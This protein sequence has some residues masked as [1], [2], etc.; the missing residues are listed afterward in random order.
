M[1]YSN[2]QKKLARDIVQTSLVTCSP[3][4]SILSVT[5][6]MTEYSCS[7]ILVMEND[8][9]L[10]IWTERDAVRHNFSLE[11]GELQPVSEVMMSPVQ[12]IPDT[13]NLEDVSEQ[14]RR[15]GFR[16]FLVED[17]KGKRIGV[18]SQTDVV[19]KFSLD[20]YLIP[21]TISSIVKLSVP[22]V[23]YDSPISLA[24]AV[25]RET[26]VDAVAVNF[27]DNSKGII[28]ER[29]I[30]K[31]I[32]SGDKTPTIEEFASKGLISLN[33]NETLFQA[34]TKMIANKI[35][36]LAVTDYTDTLIGIVNLTDILNGLRSSYIAELQNILDEKEA[37]LAASNKSLLLA[38]KVIKS[39]LEGIV[40]TNTKGIIESCNPAFTKITGYQQS[41]V[42]GKTPSILGS[43]S[44]GKS[45]YQ[46]M[47]A[48]I[49]QQGSWK[50]EI[51]NRKKNGETYHELLTISAITDEESS[52]VTHYAGI[53]SDISQL[54]KDEEQIRQLAYF[55][56]LTGLANRRR[57]LAGLEHEL[58]LALRKKHVSALL[59]I[60]LDNFKNINDTLG[61]LVG[62][63]VL[64]QAA[65]RLT[66]FLREVDTIARVGG[67]EF[68]II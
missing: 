43:G 18:I 16:H 54:K 24:T 46:K 19:L 63:K 31:A 35:R 47:W 55:D 14:F 13:M 4:D 56:S 41:E 12:S 39:S 64:S 17:N 22:T 32:A 52:E 11:K 10:G 48:Q 53:F 5:R 68:V 2:S 33:E 9:V 65:Q 20:Y 7:S 49:N 25:M 50:G 67:D 34:K 42:I 40:I 60:D 61:H 15:S 66:Q 3:A 29:D 30:I 8:E 36:H 27:P 6:K 45:F 1:N 58:A 51:I 38:Q 21:R 57:L 23:N 28:T 59:L 26:M 62:D 44:H 37:S